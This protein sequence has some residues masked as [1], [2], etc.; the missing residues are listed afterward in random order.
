MPESPPTRPTTQIRSSE[1]WRDYFERNAKSLMVIP[2]E[3]WA[4]FSD[5]ERRAIAS[6]VQGFQ[7]GESSEGGYL[8]Q[9]Q[10]ARVGSR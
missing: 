9:R 7:R 10:A 5:E 6:S 3:E 1:H 8:Y 4:G 2:W